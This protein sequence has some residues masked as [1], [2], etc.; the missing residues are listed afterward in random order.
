MGWKGVKKSKPTHRA[1]AL[2]STDDKTL[3][4]RNSKVLKR[5]TIVSLLGVSLA[6]AQ[7]T[8]CRLRDGVS[9][10]ASVAYVLCE[11]SV[12]LT[13]TDGGATWAARNTGAKGRLRAI[14]FTDVNHGFVA[15][16]GGLLL[17][18]E[19][20]GKTWQVRQTGTTEA[21]TDIE[22]AGQAGWVAGYTGVLLHS[23]DGG[24]T[25]ARQTAGTAQSLE[26]IFFLDADRG[27][28]V[29]W[30]GTIL[31]TTNGGRTWE[32][33]KSSA[34]SW[35]LS[36]VYFR[37]AKNGWAVGFAG[38]ILRSRDGGATWEAQTSGVTSWLTCVMFDDSNRGWIT[39]DDGFLVSEDG[40]ESW[41]H[42]PVDNR[43]F[44]S[45]L[46]RVKGSLWAI[47]PFGALRQAG[48]KLAWQR[49]EKLVPSVPGRS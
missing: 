44:L 13:T 16:D 14:T 48:A 19:D 38:Q 4:G 42:L 17:A 29:G 8:S 10:A 1:M 31:R 40:G 20:G 3:F 47:G 41:R 11:P 25:W 36:S 39:V 34:A 45:R 12:V 6:G 46:V 27:W 5:L 9:P 32:Q 7:E 30:A 49:I 23:S 24:H 18:T 26:S 28:A 22:F 35:S 37:D 21:L 33:I 2:Q 15:G 43:A